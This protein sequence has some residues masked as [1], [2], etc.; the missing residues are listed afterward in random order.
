MN[1]FKEKINQ[2]KEK[3]NQYKEKKICLKK[4]IFMDVIKEK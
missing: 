1:Q 3:M 2:Y 4:I